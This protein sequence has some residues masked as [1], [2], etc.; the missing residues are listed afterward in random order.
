MPTFRALFRE[1]GRRIGVNLSAITLLA[2]SGCGGGDGGSSAAP[3]PTGGISNPPPTISGQAGGTAV[4]GQSYSF[5]PQASDPNGDTLTFTITNRPNWATF[6]PSTGALTG[7][8]GSAA[9]GTYA[10]I[11]IAVSDGQSRVNLPPFSIMVSAAALGSAMVSWTPPTMRSDGTVLTNLA[12]YRI[13]YG[14]APDLYN[15]VVSVTNIGL[16]SFLVE[17]LPAGTWYF[18]VSAYDSS[19]VESELS[20]SGTKTIS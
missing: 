10:N 9:A 1:H 18:A 17:N 8:P 7:T 5:T 16:T 13:Y 19:G 15:Q 2:L 11:T 14:D 3:P 12:G 6:N 4:V 20:N